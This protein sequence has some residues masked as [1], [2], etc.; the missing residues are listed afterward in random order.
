MGNINLIIRCYFSNGHYFFVVEKVV[1]LPQP[2]IKA[3]SLEI[4]FV[5]SRATHS[6]LDKREKYL[7]SKLLKA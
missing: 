6:G 7:T 1:L 5:A 4:N 2:T 3:K